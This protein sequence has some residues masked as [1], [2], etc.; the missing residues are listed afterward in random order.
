MA[1]NRAVKPES[2]NLRGEQMVDKPKIFSPYVYFQNIGC[3][4]FK[5]YQEPLYGSQTGFGK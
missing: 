2:G 3:Q 4:Y 1:K 5:K